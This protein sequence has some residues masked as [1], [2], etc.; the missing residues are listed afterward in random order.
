MNTE[1]DKEDNN[2]M[3]KQYLKDFAGYK[4]E[5]EEMSSII[6]FLKN[7]EEYTKYGAALPK[8]ILLM[9][10]SGTGK[11]MLANI[12]ANEADVPLYSVE[13]IMKNVPDTKKDNTKAPDIINALFDKA[14]NNIP[15]VVLIDEI[16]QLIGYSGRHK[17]ANDNNALRVLLSRLDG[18]SNTNGILVIGTT[19]SKSIDPSSPLIRQGRLE[20]HIKLNYPRLEDR[21]EILSIY[22]SKNGVFR[23][24]SI[25]SLAKRTAGFT[26]A[27]LKS[28]VNLVLTKALKEKKE[29]VKDNDFYPFISQIT[30][31]GINKEINEKDLTPVAYHELG[32]FICDYKL[33]QKIGVLTIS[34]YGSASGSYRSI[35]EEE[36]K[37]EF[38]SIDKLHNMIVIS[39]GGLAATEVMVGKKYCGASNDIQKSQNIYRYMN[40][41]GLFGFDCLND[42]SS[43]FFEPSDEYRKREAEYLNQCY[44]EAKEIIADNK[45]IICNLFRHLMD[46]K[47]LYENEIKDLVTQFNS[48]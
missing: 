36:D 30:N 44:T 28:L 1:K 8:G 27:S 31:G 41:S 24:I 48:N 34:R 18:E 17:A 12:I 13:S 5:K 3:N 16:D 11:T 19:N 2:R 37:E 35:D 43:P 15:C 6:D 42:S 4:E 47:T 22:L 33:N 7:Y 40:E 21:K 20:K 14:K 10:P 9:G 38:D 32:H 25:D 26:G 39:L 45:P 23:N 46:N 29:E